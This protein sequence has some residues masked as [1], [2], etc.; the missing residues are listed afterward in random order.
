MQDLIIIGGGPA[1]LSAALN[2]AAE[3]LDVTLLERGALLGGQAGTS[4]H[5]E[6]YLGFPEGVSGEQ[7]TEHAMNQ[8]NRLGANLRVE[9][10]VVKLQHNPAHGFWVTECAGG[11]QYVSP[12][13]LVAV[14]VDYRRL[15][16]PGGHLPLVMYGAPAAEHADC[17]GE[18]VLVV[19]GGNSAGQAALNL[20]KHNARVTLLVRQPLKTSMSQY[21]IERIATNPLIDARLG[22]VT[23][24]E[25]HTYRVS[26]RCHGC[27]YEGE[28]EKV[29]PEFLQPKR[30]FAYI[31][32]EPRTSFLNECCQLDQYGFVSG[33]ADFM[34]ADS[35]LFVAG[36]VRSGSA[37]RVAVAAGEGAISASGAWRYI[38]S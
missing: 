14:G 17:A 23:G 27:A 5:I 7:L 31:G 13:V 36:D 2:G 19:G 35:G 37:K 18:D 21:L 33:N 30:V 26:M 15:P 38:Y 3:G 11:T 29:E 16:V 12:T 9:S 34:A 6:N 10:E 8:A 4:S 22:E 25:E 32:S 24:I 20:A 1:G 28:D